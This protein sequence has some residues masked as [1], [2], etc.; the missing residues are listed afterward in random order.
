VNPD[1]AAPTMPD[2][3]VPAE[4][5]REVPLEFRIFRAGKNP[6]TKGTYTFDSKSAELVMKSYATRGVEPTMDYEHQALHDPPIEAPASCRH[7]IPQIRNGELWATE[8]KWTEKAA[9]RLL[10]GEYRYFSPAFAFEVDTLRVVDVIN[11]ALTNLPALHGIDPLVAAS[12]RAKQQK[13]NRAM[14]L[15]EQITKLQQQLA[16]VTAQLSA[17]DATIADLTAKLTATAASNVAAP[18]GVAA[19]AETAAL[20]ATLSLPSSA[21]AP[22]RAVAVTALTALR[23]NVRAI[24]GA[25]D[26]PSAIGVLHA[27]KDSHT[28]VASLTA[29]VAELEGEKIG[30]EFEEVLTRVKPAAREALRKTAVDAGGGRITAASVAV[31]KAAVAAFGA[32]GVGAG[33]VAQPENKGTDQAYDPEHAAIRRALGKDQP[34]PLAAK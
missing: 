20:T 16:D 6:S 12:L 34:Q 18:E 2:P 32:S 15:Q 21:R 30:G 31:L 10:A 29:R 14:D 33:P 5:P 24:T 3:L 13:E 17:R 11:V 1:F 19:V 22:E 25:S 27:W 4:G 9:A 7:W 28:R 8:C 26:D 23:T